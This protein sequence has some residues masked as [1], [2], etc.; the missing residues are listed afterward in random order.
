VQRARATHVGFIL[1]RAAP[2]QEPK[3]CE[4]EKSWK[5]FID[6]LA[7]RVAPL[8]GNL[9]HR[10]AR[11]TGGKTCGCHIDGEYMRCAFTDCWMKRG[12]CD[13]EMSRRRRPKP[14]AQKKRGARFTV[15]L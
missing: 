2:Y 9:K 4:R 3:S 15:R 7:A 1:G 13:V 6:A 8:S 5:T 14:A 11:E 12:R 10:C